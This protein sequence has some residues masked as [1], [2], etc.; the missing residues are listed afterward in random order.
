MCAVFDSL[1]TELLGL[2]DPAIEWEIEA[3]VEVT[4]TAQTVSKT[5]AVTISQDLN[6]SFMLN[7]DEDE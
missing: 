6:N 1:A 7:V 2:A 3:G 5:A 4:N